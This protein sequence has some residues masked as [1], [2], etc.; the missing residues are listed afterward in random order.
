[1]KKNNYFFKLKIKKANA[2]KTQNKPTAIR[3]AKG[4]VILCIAVVK[5]CTIL[6]IKKYNMDYS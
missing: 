1:M 6:K 5:G 4:V 3:L 2:I